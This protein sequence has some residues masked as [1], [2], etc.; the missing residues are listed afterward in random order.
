MRVAVAALT[1][2]LAAATAAV[3]AAAPARVLGGGGLIA[4]RSCEPY[5]SSF[6]RSVIRVVR[7]D[8]S[9]MRVVRDYPPVL[10]PV[11]CPYGKSD[12]SWDGRRLLVGGPSLEILSP[13][14][15]VLRTL[16]FPFDEASWAPGRRGLTM[17]RAESDREAVWDYRF[18]GSLRRRVTRHWP[19]IGR[20]EWSP[21]GRTL[22]YDRV[23]VVRPVVDIRLVGEGRRHDRRLVA[24]SLP[25]WSPDGRKIAFLKANDVW[26]VRR[27]GSGRRRLIDN[28]PDGAAAGWHD[29]SPDGRWV[30]SGGVAPGGDPYDPRLQLVF[31]RSDGRREHRLTLPAEVEEAYPLSWQPRR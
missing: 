9:G 21:D 6:D 17:V 13:R 14:G 26:T 12:W 19:D 1:V 4:F 24:G 27:D 3:A 2:V 10:G 16:R 15:R 23:G 20:H 28:D 30:V 22:A 11:E 7:P 29:W 18:D 8:G 25:R 31:V 5:G